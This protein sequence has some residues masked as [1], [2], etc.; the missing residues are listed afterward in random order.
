MNILIWSVALI[1]IAGAPVYAQTI[2][3]IPPYQVGIAGMVQGGYHF[4]VSQ[5]SDDAVQF[6]ELEVSIQS[7]IY[8]GVDA[9]VLASV[10][11]ESGDYHLGI[12]NA[13]LSLT[14]VVDG[15]GAKVGR[16]FARF[17]KQNVLH[18]DQLPT[19]SRP[20]ALSAFFGEE[21]LGGSGLSIDYLLPLPV[22]A[23][24]E[25]ARFGSV[26][27]GFT[28]TRLWT[29]LDFSEGSDLQLG[30]S[31]IDGILDSYGADVTL[32]SRLDHGQRMMVQAEYIHHSVDSSVGQLTGGYLFGSYGISKKTEI[33]ARLDWVQQVDA[34]GQRIASLVLTER[35]TDTYFGRIEYQCD[36]DEGNPYIVGQIIFNIGAHTHGM[37]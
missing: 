27:D 6:S 17:G 28:T 16:Q 18:P 34:D 22:F 14:G 29:A 20:A 36:L 13:Y 24:I 21:N 3:A 26:K 1:L 2:P 7:K 11:E 9:H 23:Q 31:S 33:G 15:I 12:E 10:H 4:D 35:W 19:I 25:W 5:Q 32:T 37:Q 30:V 8:P